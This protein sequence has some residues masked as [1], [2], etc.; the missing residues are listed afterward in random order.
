MVDCCVLFDRSYK[1]GIII[2]RR[3]FRIDTILVGYTP[4]VLAPFTT[5]MFVTRHEGY[6]DDAFSILDCSSAEKIV[7]VVQFLFLQD[8][9]YYLFFFFVTVVVFN[10]I[11]IDL[12]VGPPLVTAVAVTALI[13][14]MVLVVHKT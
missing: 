3:V 4:R 8:K 6:D 1:V 12:M 7:V 5:G 14:R 2:C 13:L 11:I 9:K 10:I